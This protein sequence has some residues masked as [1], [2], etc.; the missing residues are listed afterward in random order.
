MRT[1]NIGIIG[2]GV[3][4][5]T[6][7]SDIQAFF[8]RLHILACAD[9]NPA[10]ARSLAEKYHIPKACLVED[11]LSDPEIEIVIDLTPPQAHT[12]MNRRILEAGKHLFS[13]KPFAP[14]VRCPMAIS[15]SN[16]AEKVK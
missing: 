5:S 7:V 10:S 14:S 8:P 12:A 6:Y 13:E 15:S 2:C 9:L 4:S 11:L 16:A 1:F 3:I